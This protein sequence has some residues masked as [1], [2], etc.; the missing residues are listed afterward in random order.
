MDL[1]HICFWAGA[2]IAM[3]LTISSDIKKSDIDNLKDL[4][5][6]I[7]SDDITRLDEVL[8]DDFIQDYIKISRYITCAKKI[9]NYLISN[10]LEGKLTYCSVDGD[11]YYKYN[12]AIVNNYTLEEIEEAVGY[13]DMDNIIKDIKIDRTTLIDMLKIC[14]NYINYGYELDNNLRNNLIDAAFSD[15]YNK[16]YLDQDIDWEINQAYYEEL[17]GNEKKAWKYFK[18]ELKENDNWYECSMINISSL[19]KL[20][21]DDL[22]QKENC[23]CLENSNYCNKKTEQLDLQMDET[24]NYAKKVFRHK[25]RVK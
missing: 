20:A 13:L 4:R 10:N 16:N 1:D 11:H 23:Q 12:S 21:T 6:A 7:L 25:L 24:L 9:N 18:K 2:V 22:L 17:A 14:N 8:T 5:E 15:I 19:Y 3:G